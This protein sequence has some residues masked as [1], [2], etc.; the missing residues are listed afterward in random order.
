MDVSTL[1]MTLSYEDYN[2]SNTI[3]SDDLLNLEHVTLSSI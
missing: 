2:N 3:V 1:C